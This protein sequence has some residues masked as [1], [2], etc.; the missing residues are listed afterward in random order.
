MYTADN[1]HARQHVDPHPG[2][3]PG[4]RTIN[5]RLGLMTSLRS[6][7]LDGNP[8]KIVRRELLSGPIS[9]LQEHLRT[10]LSEEVLEVD[11]HR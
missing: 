3:P 10:K 11:N 9:A 4:C 1:M 6:L 7:P 2:S 5:P 8:T